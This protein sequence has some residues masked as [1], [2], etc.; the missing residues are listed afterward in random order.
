MNN[1]RD[2]KKRLFGSV[3]KIAD[4]G[5]FSVDE[6][7]LS[8]PLEWEKA[9]V[10]SFCQGCGTVLEVNRKGAEKLAKLAGI[11][12]PSSLEGYYF[13]T[14]TCVLCQ[15]DDFSVEFKKMSK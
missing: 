10:R 7:E 2:I 9:V 3:K 6:A 4:K 15:G 12:L 14:K 5:N 8:E 13:Q 1:D 11:T